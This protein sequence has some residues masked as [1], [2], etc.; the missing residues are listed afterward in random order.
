FKVFWI[1]NSPVMVVQANKPFSSGNVTVY[2]EGLAVPIVLNV[3][4]G[5]PDTKAGIWTVDSRL[6]M[7]IPS[8][9]PAALPGAAPET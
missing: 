2:L 7:R 5:E 6:D 8:R 4:S 9:G 3:T 1:P